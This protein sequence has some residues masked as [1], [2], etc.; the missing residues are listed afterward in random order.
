MG[1]GLNIYIRWSWDS[2]ANGQVCGVRLEEA[3]VLAVHL[4]VV[5]CDINPRFLSPWSLIS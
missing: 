5:F 4:F 2:E 3:G 1:V